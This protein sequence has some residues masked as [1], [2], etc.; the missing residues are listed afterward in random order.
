VPYI[1]PDFGPFQEIAVNTGIQQKLAETFLRV[2]TYT[3]I[4]QPD[5]RGVTQLTD[6]CA[7]GGW[8]PDSK[9]IIC[10]SNANGNNNSYE[11]YLINVSSR[12]S[13]RLTDTPYNEFDPD[14]AP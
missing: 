11:M 9:W 6:Q 7:G 1:P 10:T 5:G 4:M 8:S 14:W 12:D 2:T 3:M 13:F